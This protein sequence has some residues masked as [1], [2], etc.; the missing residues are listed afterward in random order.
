MKKLF[1][2]YIALGIASPSW[3]G[4]GWYFLR[5]P[6]EERST[7]KE[8]EYPCGWSWKL[9]FADGGAKLPSILPQS[10]EAFKQYHVE[11]AK[12]GA[13]EKGKNTPSLDFIIYGWENGVCIAADDPRLAK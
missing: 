11:R 9:R 13:K 5:P 12:K 4:Q 6:L 1:V 3:A 10:V 2:V 7:T 8:G